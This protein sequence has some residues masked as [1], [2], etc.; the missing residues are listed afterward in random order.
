[1]DGNTIAI[2]TWSDVIL[3]LEEDASLL[4]AQRRDRISAIRRV[5]E[6]I[7]V[8]PGA[9]P[10]SLEHMRPLLKR[11]RPAK[12]GLQPK[13]WSN[14]RSNLRAALAQVRPQRP[15]RHLDPAW[16]RW[17]AAL[18][19]Q[20]MKVGLSRLITY[21]EREGIAP[22]AV[23]D[24][25]LER[26]LAELEADTLLPNPRD[27]H[28]RTCRLWNEAVERVPGWPGGRVSVPPSQAVRRTLPLSTYPERLQKEFELCVSP[29]P[30][31]RFAQHGHKKKLRPATVTQNNVLIELALFAAVEAGTDPASIATLDYLFEPPV[32]QAILERYC[33][34]D[35][36]QTPRPT[37]HNL[38]RMLI[39]FAKQRLGSTPAAL[40]RIAELS[41]L[42]RCLG[43]QPQ[44]LTE[45]NR[46]LLR[47]LLDPATLASLLLLPERLANWASRTSWA[48][49]ALAVELAVAIAILL[50]A[51]MR[52]SNLAGLHL[53][54]HLVRPGGPRSLL[55]IDIPPEEVKN[56]VRLLYELSQR[57]TRVVDRFIRDFRPR[58]ATPDNPYLFPLGTTHK[59]K[60]WFSRQIRDVVAKWVGID[61]TPH[62]FRHLA[63][64]LMQRN[65]PG[66]FAALAQL[67]GHKKIDTV[68]RYYAELDTLS[69]GRE[70]DAIVEA[71]LA[72][73]YPP[74][75]GHK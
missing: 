66:S 43:P 2:L 25:V 62:Q 27:C 31:D 38:A 34:D 9:V 74:H 42:R 72:K 36:D 17:R 14:I 56:E 75:R 6:I 37:A 51:P 11:V 55:L 41:R 71:E 68:I 20:R 12:H 65:S 23:C 53:K 13:T 35:A 47:E 30:G 15:Q 67:L 10:A 5:C 50:I 48:R 1:M 4:P 73:A 49:G 16:A 26:F 39:G 45:K 7:G 46:R 19:N 32:F 28:R 40:D 22:A 54:Q 59:T 58:F 57:V 61:M 33:E 8:N 3:C 60:N 69:A 21:S 18:P 52:I 70:F 44:G 24:A 63:G 29:P 64:Q